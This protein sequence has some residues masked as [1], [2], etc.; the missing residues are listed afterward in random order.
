MLV[1]DILKLKGDGLFGIAP[2]TPLAEAVTVMVD[3]DVG[4]LVVLR[5]EG[6]VGLITFREVLAAIKRHAGDIH[7]VTVKDIMVRNPVVADPEDS[8]D[9]VRAIMTDQHVRYLPIVH[10]RKLLGILSFHDIARAALKLANFENKLLKQYIKN[11]PEES[12]P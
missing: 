5:G 6:M 1:K 4:S 9:Q 2:D 3:K 12:Q 8:M 11:W 10:D 7:E